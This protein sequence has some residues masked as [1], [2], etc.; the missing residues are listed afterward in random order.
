MI[1]AIEWIK[2]MMNYLA[3]WPKF[4]NFALA[5]QGNGKEID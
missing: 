4:C 5:I 2:K 3:V 1:I